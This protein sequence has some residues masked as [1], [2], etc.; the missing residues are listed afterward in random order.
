MEPVFEEG[1]TTK[2]EAQKKHCQIKKAAHIRP[3]D[4]SGKSEARS[5]PQQDASAKGQHGR[6]IPFSTSGNREAPNGILQTPP[7]LG[8]APQLFPFGPSESNQ[9]PNGTPQGTSRNIL[10]QSSNNQHPGPFINGIIKKGS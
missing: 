4:P 2:L 6:R 1:S 10:A 9:T 7:A 5:V 3:K 8:G